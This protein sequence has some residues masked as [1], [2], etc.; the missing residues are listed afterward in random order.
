MLEGLDLNK[1]MVRETY[2]SKRDALAV[3]LGFL[4]RECRRLGI[5]V[6][7]VFE[8]YAGAGKGFYMDFV[9]AYSYMAIGEKRTSNPQ[10]PKGK[11]ESPEPSKATQNKN[12]LDW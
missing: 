3:K 7:V 8:G 6:M 10:K 1:V 12:H 4:Q 5:P 11:T 9:G 2:R